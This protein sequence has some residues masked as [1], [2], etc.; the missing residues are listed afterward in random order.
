MILL[1]LNSQIA[2]QAAFARYALCLNSNDGC[3][4]MS[5]PA[6]GQIRAVFDSIP[7]GRCK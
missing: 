6:D 7:I 2:K 1:V 4:V 3:F 5:S